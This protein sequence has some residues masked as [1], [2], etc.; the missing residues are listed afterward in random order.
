M[1]TKTALITV[2]NL[3]FG[4]GK[5]LVLR[6]LNF[7]IP[8][9][10]IT[11][12]MGA[13]GSG[14]STLLD[15]LTKNAPLKQ[16]QIWFG[17]EKLTNISL[18]AFAKK[19][20]VVHQYHQEVE[21]MLVGDLIAMARMANRSFWEP[22]CQE[23]EEK[24]AWALDVTALGAYVYR[25]IQD[26][27]GGEKQRVWIAMALVQ[28]TDILMLDEP[29]TYLDINYQLEILK[30]IK[31]I[32]Q[33]LGLTIVLVLHDINQALAIS[34]QLIGLKDGKIYAQGQPTEVLNQGF[35][36]AVL[37]VDLPLVEKD[38]KHFVITSLIT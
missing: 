34:D 6:D 31:T 5:H 29:T 22:S 17:P 12:I 2:Q 24:I 1:T 8:K 35:I 18:K 11:T 16:G 7:I 20:A 27:S 38:G 26:L 19:V 10:K 13:N 4:Y 15:L 23:D 3:T 21:G 33:K 32:N 28:Q 30:L 9:G 36:Q 14:K 37:G 25:E